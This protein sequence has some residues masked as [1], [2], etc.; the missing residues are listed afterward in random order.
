[1]RF[2]KEAEKRFLAEHIRVPHL[3][4]PS[5][6]EELDVAAF[7]VLLHG[8]F[9]NFAEGICLWMLDRVE[10]SWLSQKRV[11]HAAAAVL[12]HSR[13]PAMTPSPTPLFDRL[14]L[15][16]AAAKSDLSGVVQRNHGIALDDLRVLLEPVG[17][18]V[19]SDP[20]RSASLDLL[21]SLRHQWAHQYRF[22]ARKAK[23]AADVVVVANDCLS[24][25][26]ELA[27]SAADLRA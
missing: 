25:A 26:K 14:R 9:E 22:A 27:H 10:R 11:S 12:L 19:T 23:S 13:A 1:M 16:L 15:A 21:V 17:I 18:T 3:G 24:L 6:A 7:V 20:V 4:A 2:R 5:R 8:A